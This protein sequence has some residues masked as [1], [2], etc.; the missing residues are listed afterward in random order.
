MPKLKDLTG[1]RFGKLVVVELTDK[2]CGH[3]VVWKCK[4]DC[5]NIKYVSS[6]NLCSGRTNSCGCLY[7]KNDLIGLKFGKLIVIDSTDLR[8][9][10]GNV[11][12]KCKCECG[13]IDYVSTNNL[14]N[15][16]VKSCGC[17]RYKYNF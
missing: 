15:G 8:S 16:R 3:S 17:S 6:N 9:K 12:W 7:Q 5:G 1:L 4:C 10:N 2:R 13:N 11:I 14:L